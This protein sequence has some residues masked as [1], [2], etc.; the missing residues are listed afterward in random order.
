[1]ILNLDVAIV[2]SSLREVLMEALESKYCKRPNCCEYDS[3]SGLYLQYEGIFLADGGT[4]DSACG[5]SVMIFDHH[6]FHLAAIR[7]EESTR[8]FMANEKSII[9]STTEGY[10]K[11]LIDHGGSRARN[12]PSAKFTILEPDEVWQDNPRATSAKWVY[13]KEF[14]SAPYPYTVSLLTDRQDEGGKVL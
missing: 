12:L 14:D 13:I 7:T 9:Q 1:M 11:Y 4:L 6:F 2:H 8:L 3:I 10:G 5:H